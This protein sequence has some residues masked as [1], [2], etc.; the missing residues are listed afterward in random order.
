MERRTIAVALVTLVAATLLYAY[1]L[2]LRIRVHEVE[3]RVER[4]T[5][6]R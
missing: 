2:G 1:L 3:D 4:T 5:G 6:G